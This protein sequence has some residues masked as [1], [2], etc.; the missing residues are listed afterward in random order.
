MIA[1]LLTTGALAQTPVGLGRL[2]HPTW[3]CATTDT[4]SPPQ[5]IC[6]EAYGGTYSHMESVHS[7]EV[8]CHW[9]DGLPD[10]DTV[11]LS[12]ECCAPEGQVTFFEEIPDDVGWRAVVANGLS[13]EGTGRGYTPPFSTPL[14]FGGITMDASSFAG[15]TVVLSKAKALGV[16]TGVYRIDA[17]E[18]APFEGLNVIFEWGNDWYPP[19]PGD[20]ADLQGMPSEGSVVRSWDDSV[21]WAIVGGA[22]LVAPD[23]ETAQRLYPVMMHRGDLAVPWMPTVPADGSLLREED[24]SIWVWFGSAPFHVPDPDTLQR[25]YG[26]EP[27]L[28]V[29]TGL[30]AM[31]TG[32]PSGGVLFREESGAVYAILGGARFHVP[33]PPT[34]DRLYATWPLYEVWNGA[35]DAFPAV[36]VDGAVLQDDD[37]TAF[38]MVGGAP[39]RAPSLEAAQAVAPWSPPEPI[40]NGGLSALPVTPADGTLVRETSSTQVYEVVGGWLYTVNGFYDVTAVHVVWDGGLS[41]FPLALAWFGWGW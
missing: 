12:F 1:T 14:R 41:G 16:H 27:L 20:Y 3:D 38:L 15:Q 36:P 11:H 22:A 4:S 9:H 13:L 24:G 30:H 23:T 26:G 25:L 5:Q 19:V 2:V 18:F 17:A 35:T 6:F 28:P 37:G 31:F 33:D 40:W 29:W 21:V 39:L 10:G 8:Q 32:L 7:T 34:Y